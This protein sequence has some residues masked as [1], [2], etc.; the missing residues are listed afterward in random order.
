MIV[1]PFPSNS[2]RRVLFFPMRWKMNKVLEQVSMYLRHLD[3][4]RWLLCMTES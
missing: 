2:L 4:E 3:V 1:P